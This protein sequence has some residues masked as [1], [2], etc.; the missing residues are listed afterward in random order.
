MCTCGFILLLFS[1]WCSPSHS[2]S[3]IVSQRT[4]IKSNVHETTAL[5]GMFVACSPLLL[6]LSL[7]SLFFL[8]LSFSISLYTRL[9]FNYSPHTRTHVCTRRA[10]TA[11][12]RVCVRSREEDSYVFADSAVNVCKLAPISHARRLPA[13]M[14]HME[15]L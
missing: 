4:A 8:S 6:F 15:I 3:R 14:G 10:H 1:Q 7:F 12:T 11:V 13:M 9:P 2:V 5:N